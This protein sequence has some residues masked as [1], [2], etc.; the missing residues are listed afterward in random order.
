MRQLARRARD[1]VR[2]GRSRFESDH[3]VHRQVTERFLA[4]CNQ[5]DLDGLV[6]VLAADVCLV[7]DGGGRAPAPRRPVLGAEA[8]PGSSSSFGPDCRRRRSVRPR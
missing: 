5:G 7:A 3:A 4:A 2:T 1:H 8:S 6:R